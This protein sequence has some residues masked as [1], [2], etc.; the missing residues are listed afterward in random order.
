M[1]E[2]KKPVLKWVPK[3]DNHIVK[4]LEQILEELKRLNNVR[5]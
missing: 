2:T 1:T 5:T 4:L 3:P